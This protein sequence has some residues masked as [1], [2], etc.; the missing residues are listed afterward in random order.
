MFRRGNVSNVTGIIFVFLEIDTFSSLLQALVD[1]DCDVSMMNTALLDLCTYL[2]HR[3]LDGGDDTEQLQALANCIAALDVS[4]QHSLVQ[5]MHL[6]TSTGED[7]VD[8][9]DLLRMATTERSVT[10]N[11]Q[12]KFELAANTST[13]SSS[14]TS[15]MYKASHTFVVERTRAKGNCVGSALKTPQLSETQRNAVWTQK[16]GGSHCSIQLSASVG[17]GRRNELQQ[18]QQQQRARITQTISRYAALLDDAMCAMVRTRTGIRAGASVRADCN[19][20]MCSFGHLYACLAAQRVV[21]GS[22]RE[23]LLR[24]PASPNLL[25]A[26]QRVLQAEM[27]EE[28]QGGGEEVTG[29]DDRGH[30]RDVALSAVRCFL[31][32]S[33][34]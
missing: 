33:H 19:T 34:R 1:E 22:H 15:G 20:I 14:S 28:E 29:L 2:L 31:T 13:S 24:A 3:L 4:M 6:E 10:G 8:D 11:L 7:S 23:A 18:Q 5:L 30:R 16:D 26:L 27:D 17:S 21:T 25:G 9:V 12:K 32:C